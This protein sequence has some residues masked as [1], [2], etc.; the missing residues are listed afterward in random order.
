MSSK[1]IRKQKDFFSDGNISP[2]ECLEEALY[3]LKKNFRDLLP[4][5]AFGTV[6]F[7]VAVIFFIN[8]MNLRYDALRVLPQYSFII[9]FFFLWKSIFQTFFCKKVMCKLTGMREEK[10]TFRL[11]FNILLIQGIVQPF[12]LYANLI[13]IILGTQPLVFSFNTAFMIEDSFEKKS[14][15]DSLKSSLGHSFK[16]PTQNY[17]IYFIVFIFAFLSVLNTIVLIFLIPKFLKIFLGIHSH[18]ADY[19]TFDFLLNLIFNSTFWSVVF[20]VSYFSTD[21]LLKTA[22][23]IRYFYAESTKKAYDIKSTLSNFK[24]TAIILIFASM[25]LFLCF[26]VKATSDLGTG[27]IFFQEKSNFHKEKLP[28]NERKSEELEKNICEVLKKR[29]FA[30]RMPRDDKHEF[31]FI[32]QLIIDFFTK[33]Q[34]WRDTILEFLR[35]YF[36]VEGSN[37]GLFAN[38]LNF[39]S[40]H[41]ILLSVFVLLFLCPIVFIFLKKRSQVSLTSVKQVSKR[42]KADLGDE[43]IRP[44]FM[45]FSEWTE[46]A[47]S[48][49]EKNDFRAALRAFFLASLSILGEKKLLTIVSCKTNREY[50]RELNRRC[51][52]N[53]NIKS[54][55]LENMT[56]FE[57]A[58]YGDYVVSR[59]EMLFVQGNMDSIITNLETE[60]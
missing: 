3:L 42:K 25:A 32:S 15:L 51:S 40:K 56:I 23:T 19:G 53:D 37:N 26:E 55:F 35:K 46:I 60:K 54:A 31:N 7:L 52:Y 30:W 34:D 39:I 5:Y 29:E 9:A 24:K 50:L 4:L 8:D 2:V 16:F 44:D 49:I 6:P 20:A 17:I 59:N 13:A 14:F 36:K 58:W 12:S 22:Y 28:I 10:I 11:F 41:Y 43:N 57:K 27:D 21:P 38:I 1:K 45:A 18:Y 48:M 47:N 33:I